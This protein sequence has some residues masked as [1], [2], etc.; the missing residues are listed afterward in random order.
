M[1]AL[2]LTNLKFSLVVPLLGSLLVSAFFP[3]SAAGQA[4]D[5]GSVRDWREDSELAIIQTYFELLRLPNIA[6]ND[7]DVSAN[8]RMLEALFEAEGLDVQ[9]SSELYP[10]HARAPLVIGRYAADNPRGT[11]LLYIHYDGQPVNTELWTVCP[12]FDPCVAD[13]GGPITLTPNTELDPQWRIYGRSASDDKAPIMSLL[14]ALRALRATGSEPRWNLFVML[15]GQEESGS[16]NFREYLRDHGDAIE[17]DLA[18]A[19]DGPRHPS[20]LPT[21]YYGV[22]GGASLTLQV[23]TAQQDLHSGNYGNWAPDPSIA[24]AKLLATMKADDGRVTIAGFYD[25]VLPLTDVELAALA[26]IPDIEDNL[27]ST[28]AIAAPEQSGTRLE[29]KL[30]WP[31]LNVLAMD[32]GGGFS[33]PSRTAIPGFAQARLAMRLVRGI[34]PQRQIQL[35]LNHI[36]EQG[37]YLVEN[38]EPTIEER[39]QYAKLASVSYGGGRP[40]TRVSMEMP[41]ARSVA[42]ALTLDGVQPV[43]LPTLG[44][45]L[46]F[47]DFSEG[48]GIPTVGVAL[49]NHDNNQHGPDENLR[50]LNLWQGIEIVSRLMTMD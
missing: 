22:R 32:S 35:L 14:Q 8:A 17:A 1:R 30:N 37:Y 4:N 34:D 28:F 39:Q 50:L 21:M 19:L 24:M 23:H 33:A 25:Q 15:D 41:L 7:G 43:Q 5:Y 20:T 47:G 6:R 29:T 11:L 45:S 46:P 10:H 18:I 40:A 48:L 12:P 36:R 3:L 9:L 27:A 2:R 26:A 38:R 44:G 13:E 16:T 49:V 42:N 31:T